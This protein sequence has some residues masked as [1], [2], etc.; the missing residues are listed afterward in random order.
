MRTT[1]TMTRT[2]RST[3][4]IIMM[5]T[6]KKANAAFKIVSDHNYQLKIRTDGINSSQG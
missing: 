5:K 6:I 4:I 3:A 2:T 1:T